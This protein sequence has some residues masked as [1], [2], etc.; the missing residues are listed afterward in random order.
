M[1]VLLLDTYNGTPAQIDIYR[2]ITGV[3]APILRDAANGTDY[4]GAHV[5]KTSWSSI[6]TAW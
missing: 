5:L 3:T 2:Q 4:D 1:Q 6:K